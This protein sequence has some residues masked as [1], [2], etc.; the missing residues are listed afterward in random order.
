MRFLSKKD[1]KQIALYSYA[2]TARLEAEGK[3]P[4]RVRLGNGKY[5][6][7]GYVESE[8]M[9]WC[10]KRIAERDEARETSP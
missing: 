3:F 4:K 1:V 10:E 9:E 8:I 2:H 7:V 5:A 6:R